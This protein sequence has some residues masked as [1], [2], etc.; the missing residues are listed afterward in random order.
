MS[1]EQ[2]TVKD[3]STG[4]SNGSYNYTSK[5]GRIHVADN[6]PDYRSL[7][8]DTS[9]ADFVA[10]EVKKDSYNPDYFKGS[11]WRLAPDPNGWTTNP[12]PGP[13]GVTEVRR[14]GYSLEQAANQA[15]KTR[16]STGVYYE[17][18]KTDGTK[19]YVNSKGIPV[20]FTQPAR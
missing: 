5:S 1:D 3:A 4:K 19:G 9:K 2:N 14:G 16:D 13:A 17:Y 11:D 8:L 20:Q 12:P 6:N 15:K 10:P 7:F 18:N